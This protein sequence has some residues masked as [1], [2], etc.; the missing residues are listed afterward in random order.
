M[1]LIS[2]SQTKFEKCIEHF[3]H[4]LSGVR[5]GRASAA[6]L[7]SVVVESYGQRMPISHVASITVS[8]PKTIT[9]QPWDKSNFASIEKGI[10]SANLGLNPINDGN[11]IR[12]SI[13]PMT[14]ER[15]KDMVRLIGKQTEAARVSIRNA[16][17]EVLKEL[18][19]S[20][21]LGMSRDQVESEKKNLQEIVDKYNDQIKQ[22]AAAKEKDLMTI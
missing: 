2:D 9:I 20:E 21:E 13:P 7:D 5:T 12:L 14:E 4:E 17:E 15:R 16:R 10:Q 22:L 19:R 3:K 11:V 18:K 1:S 8:D 6:L